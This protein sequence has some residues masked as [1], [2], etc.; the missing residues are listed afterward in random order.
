MGK[1]VFI[2]V[3]IIGLIAAFVVYVAPMFMPTATEVV[4]PKTSVIER[5][6]EVVE[7]AITTSDTPEKVSEPTKSGVTPKTNRITGTVVSFSGKGLTE[8]PREA[9]MVNEATTLDLS[10]NELSGALPAEIRHLTELEVLDLSYN[11]FTGVPAE[12]GQ[13]SNLRVLN[14]SN[15]PITGLPHEIGNLKKLER[16]ELSGTN[17]SK[18]DLAVI[19]EG[20]SPDVLIVVD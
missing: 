20:L 3:G 17:Y 18:Q 12:V 9:L 1:F 4:T 19:E 5:A 2:I 10:H 11:N 7:N 14:L 13:L 15:N 16:L 6:R 8:L